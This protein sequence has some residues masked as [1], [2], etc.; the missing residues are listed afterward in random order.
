MMNSILLFIGAFLASFV[1]TTGASMILIR[2]VLRANR[3]RKGVSHIFIFFIFLV[4]NIS[5]LVT[6]LGEPPLFFGFLRGVPFIWT[7]KLLPFWIFTVFTLLVIFYFFDSYMF[8]REG[9][10]S[11]SFLEAVDELPQ[12]KVGIKGK[13]NFLFLLMVVGSLFLPQILREIIML[14]AV[15]LSIYFTSV[16]LREENSFTHHPIVEV[17]I[18]FAGIFVTMVPAMSILQVNGG[19]L[20]IAE[21]WQF[22]R[23]TG[24]LSSFLDNAPTYMIF[25][26]AAQSVAQTRWI[27]QGLVV[28]VPELYLKAICAGAVVRGANTY[29]GNGPNF[30]AKA[31]CKGNDVNM[32]SFFGYMI[33]SLAILVP[34]F[35]LITFIFF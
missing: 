26:S 2:P 16:V 15:A 4:S 25:F 3:T 23:A 7:I 31:I 19:K 8:K 17:A 30:M 21:P 12:K 18:L 24:I 22:F 6:P 34:V 1:G 33:W 32:P 5:G 29:I 9:K 14:A 13:I 11:S 27:L 20:G 35:I 28:G 10:S